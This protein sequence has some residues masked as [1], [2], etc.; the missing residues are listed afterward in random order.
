MSDIDSCLQMSMILVLLPRA[1]L[2]SSVSMHAS[3]GI[4]QGQNLKNVSGY[5][6]D[7][8][9]HWYTVEYKSSYE[10]V[11]SSIQCN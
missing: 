9:C 8:Y 5:Y 10:S 6:L 11:L 4:K 1:W 3:R 2:D 7:T